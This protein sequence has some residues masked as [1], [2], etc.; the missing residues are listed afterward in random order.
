MRFILILELF[1]SD[2]LLLV[3]PNTKESNLIITGKLYEYLRSGIPIIAIANPE[4]DAAKIVNQTKSGIVVNHDDSEGIKN[5]IL[6]KGQVTSHDIKRFSRKE[7]THSLSE[8]FD[9]I[10]N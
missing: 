3:I 4:G 5:I 8:V 1:E 6:Q 10:Q 7:L 9:R 2:F